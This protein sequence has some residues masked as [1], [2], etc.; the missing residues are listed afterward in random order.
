MVRPVDV[1]CRD[2]LRQIVERGLPED[3]TLDGPTDGNWEPED[4]ARALNCPIRVIPRDGG[5]E[6][7]VGTDEGEPLVVAERAAWRHEP[8]GS[9]TGAWYDLVVPAAASDGQVWRCRRVFCLLEGSTGCPSWY[10]GGLF[11]FVTE[12]T[13][14]QPVPR[15]G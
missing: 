7:T 3:A 6:R 2:S 12:A 13:R 14:I 10:Q 9:G 4:A 11:L 8:G 5:P 1:R 15:R